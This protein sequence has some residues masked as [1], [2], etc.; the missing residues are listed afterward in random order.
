MPTFAANLR[1]I[2]CDHEISQRE[3]G[4]RTGI[5]SQTISAYERGFRTNPHL[6]HVITLAR[7]LR[8][9][10]YDL[11]PKLKRLA[12]RPLRQLLTAWPYLDATDRR[13]LRTYIQ[14]I[15]DQYEDL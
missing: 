12:P 8:C 13:N 9:T 4:R 10:P 11:E 1:R 6:T 3:L 14:D 7:H 5:P 2:R 15:L